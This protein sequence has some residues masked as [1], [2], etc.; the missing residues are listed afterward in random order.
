MRQT[1]GP[2]TV[3]TQLGAIVIVATML[4]LGLGLWLDTQLHTTPW[5]TLVGLVAGVL[6]AVTGVYRVILR[7]YNKLG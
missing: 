2:L 4:P 6:A 7:Q 3:I 5:I 1:I